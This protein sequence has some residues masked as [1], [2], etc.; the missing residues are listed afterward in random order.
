MWF[1]EKSIV[2][3]T[4]GFNALI[5][6]LPTVFEKTV[7]KYNSFEIEFVKKVVSPLR[8]LPWLSKDFK[9]Q[10]GRVAS[11]QLSE[12]IGKSII[13]NIDSLDLSNGKK[14]LAI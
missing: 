7:Q 11:K 2:T 12:T 9:G 4:T 8:E 14:R 10:Q 1:N 5:A 13:S 3:K 6:V